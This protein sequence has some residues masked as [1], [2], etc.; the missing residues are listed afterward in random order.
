MTREELDA[1]IELSVATTINELKPSVNT[2]HRVFRALDVALRL[3][4]DL[5]LSSE[6]YEIIHGW[7]GQG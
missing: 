1:I 5:E 3:I 7:G 6:D 2:N 4:P